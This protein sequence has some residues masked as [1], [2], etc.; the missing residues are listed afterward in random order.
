MGIC[1]LLIRL[2]YLE[3]E[4]W[5]LKPKILRG[6]HIIHKKHLQRKRIV[7]TYSGCSAIFPDP[8]FNL[9]NYLLPPYN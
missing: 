1:F 9:I 3:L 2:E 7:R 8:T 6:S 4:K 5:K